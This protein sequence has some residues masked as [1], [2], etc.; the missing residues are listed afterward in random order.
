MIVYGADDAV[1]EWVSLG[2]TGRKDS[3]KL[4]KALGVLCD[5]QLVAGIVFN[6]YQEKNDSS[7]LSIEMTI[8]SV[9]KRWCTR[10]NLRK[11]FAYPFAQLRLERVQA[12]CSAHNEGVIMFLKK[13]GF[14]Q[15]G[16]HRMAYFDGGDALSFGML[17][18][19]CRWL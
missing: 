8:Y 18:H 7:P 14:M 19:E 10:H 4:S 1:A 11:I 15:E 9:D 6:N 5:G 3:F 13:I 12:V 17:K 16:R 2:L